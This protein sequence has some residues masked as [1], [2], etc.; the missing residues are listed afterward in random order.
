[1]TVTGTRTQA[2]GPDLEHRPSYLDL[3]AKPDVSSAAGRA[4]LVTFTDLMAL[5]LAFFVLLFSMSQI[6]QAKWQG[7]VD[8]LASELN[9]LRKVENFKPALEYQP[10][11]EAVMPGAD[12]DY[13]TPIIREQ[14]AAHP[15]LAQATIHRAAERLV[16]SLPVELLFGAGAAV[17]A[18]QTV[19]LGSALVSVLRNL[20]NSIEVEAQLGRAGAAR[21]QHADWELALAQAAAFTGILTHAGYTGRI[22]ARAMAATGPASGRNSGPARSQG[23]RLDVVIHE[24]EQEPQ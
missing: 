15:L 14:I 3:L 13:L 2:G 10:E 6:E 21:A 11:E 22:V 18:P 9:T 20:N 24:S 19:E 1:M 12:L 4:W 5:M 23:A 7:L 16:I 8:A 17:P